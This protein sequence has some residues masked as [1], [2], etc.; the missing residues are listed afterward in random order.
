[1]TKD[2]FIARYCERSCITKDFFDKHL[3]AIECACDA[4]NC[5]GWAAVSNDPERIKIHLELYAPRKQ[6]NIEERG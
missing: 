6:A 4:D 1:M 5:Q 3:V 2:D